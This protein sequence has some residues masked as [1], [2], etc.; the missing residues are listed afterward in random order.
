[1]TVFLTLPV[2]QGLITALVE[3][4][5]LL[6]R[7]SQTLPREVGTWLGLCVHLGLLENFISCDCRPQE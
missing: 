4:I 5:E 6:F 3:A 2:T 7:G 1:M